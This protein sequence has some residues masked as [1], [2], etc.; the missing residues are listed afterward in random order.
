VEA[1]PGTLGG[2]YVYAWNPPALSEV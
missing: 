1:P 2:A